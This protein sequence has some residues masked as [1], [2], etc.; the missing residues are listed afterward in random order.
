MHNKE[1]SVKRF[2]IIVL[3]TSVWV[4]LSEV[5]RYF[6]LVMPRVKA[7][8]GH[9]AGIAEMNWTIFGIW[10]MWDTMLTAMTVYLFWL[11]S[12]L[13][14]NNFRSVAVSAILSWMF[15][16]VLYWVG[17]ANMGYSDWAILSI[18]LPLSLLELLVANFIA[19]RLYLRYEKELA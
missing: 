4:H 13:F 2:S 16:F 15:F 6:V 19:S 1:F 17:V 14:G 18:T 10:G 12:K 11:N 7:Y 8:W 9:T 3:I 5:F